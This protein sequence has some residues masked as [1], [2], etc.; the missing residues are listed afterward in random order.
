MHLFSVMQLL[1]CCASTT[2]SV[3]QLDDMRNIVHVFL[4]AGG[5]GL[6]RV[7]LYAK[8]QRLHDSQSTPHCVF[9]CTSICFLY[10][11]ASKNTSCV[12]CV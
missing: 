5:E 7:S 3:L 12:P 11:G 6:G 2:L 10:E 9:V 8:T 1:Q 4:R